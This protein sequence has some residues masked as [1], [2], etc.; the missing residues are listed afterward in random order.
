MPDEAEYS[1][2]DPVLSYGEKAV[3]LTF[4][5]SG[6]TEVD[7]IKRAFARE[8][9]RMADLRMAVNTDHEARRLA[10][11]AITKMQTAQMW[12]VKAATWPKLTEDQIANMLPGNP[13]TARPEIPDA[14]P[15][16]SQKTE[17]ADVER[18]VDVLNENKRLKERLAE[19]E[20]QQTD[21]G[22]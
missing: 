17:S 10:S 4:N 2:A 16:E 12:A 11:V 21:D 13:Q 20:A 19:I 9:D 5:P 7:A 22:K 14:E 18:D 1:P 8:I 6:D 15:A 3:G